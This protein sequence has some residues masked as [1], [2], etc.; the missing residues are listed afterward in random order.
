ILKLAEHI[1]GNYRILGK[2]EED[3]EWQAAGQEILA[4]LGL[5][6]YDVEQLI[7]TY[8]ESGVAVQNY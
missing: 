6:E 8:Q 4:Y 1:C 7:L 2:Q 5:G 3:L